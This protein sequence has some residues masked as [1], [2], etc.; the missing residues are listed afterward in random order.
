MRLL[1]EIRW[2]WNTIG[3]QLKV[4]YGDIKSAEYNVAYDDTTKLSEVLQVW[5][6]KRTCEVSWRTII[7]VVKEPPIENNVVAEKIHK[8]LA[9]SEIRNEYLSSDQPGK[10]KKYIYLMFF[11][12]H[13]IAQVITTFKSPPPVQTKPTEIKGITI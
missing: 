12:Y 8:F 13:S 10:V 4:H 5:I 7:T 9:R 2:R 6:Y 11:L 1:H 3:E